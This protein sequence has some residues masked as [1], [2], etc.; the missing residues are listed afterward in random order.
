MEIGRALASEGG[1]ARRETLI[2]RG[3]EPKAIVRALRSEQVRRPYRG[4]YALPGAPGLAIHAAMFRGTP[5]CVTLLRDWGLPVIDAD[6]SSHLRVPANRGRSGVDRRPRT[7]VVLHRAAAELC[8]VRA[9]DTIEVLALA[10]HCLDPYALIAAVD[11]ALHTSLLHEHDL[12][13]LARRAQV[14][15]EWLASRTCGLSE[16]PGETYARLALLDRGYAVRSQVAHFRDLRVDLEAEGMVDI[17]VNSRAYHSDPK[18]FQRDHERMRRITQLGRIPLAFTVAEVFRDA[19]VVPR[20]VEKVIG[21][22]RLG[23]G[24]LGVRITP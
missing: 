7:G 16:S 21:A 19:T 10:R 5:T 3:V 11:A 20:E 15:P 14:T 8:G 1:A 13:E 2:A 18:A 22:P 9:V 24:P 4:V 17:E 23:A 12:P 6:H